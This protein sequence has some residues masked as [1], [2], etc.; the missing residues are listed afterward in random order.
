MLKLQFLGAAET[1]TG[2]KY[3]LSYKNTKLLIDCGL[4]QGTKN[5][6]Q[7]NWRALAVAETDID[8]VILTHAH[9]DHSGY[10][11]VLAKRGYR[12]PVYCSE[13]TLAL[14]R[15]LLPD[16]GHLQE[17]DARYANKYKVTRHH[18]AQAL[19]TE[20][21]ARRAL[22][23]FKPIALRQAVKLG[24]DITLELV[25]AG[26]IVGACSVRLRLGGRSVVFSGDVGRPGDALMCAPEPLQKTDYLI[27]ESTYG[28]RLHPQEDP[29]KSLRE[30]VNRTLKRGG[31]VLIPAFA[32][33]RA[34]VILHMLERL[35]SSA[36]IPTV[37]VYLNSPMALAA[38]E[39][40]NRFTHEHRL[41]RQDCLR[42]VSNTRFVASVEESKALNRQVFP[43]IIIS[44]SGMASGGR[45]IHHLKTLIGNHR[46]SV[47]FAGFQAP[48]TRGD[49][50]LKGVNAIKMHGSYYGVDAE[51]VSIEGLSA[52]ADYRELIDWLKPLQQAPKHTFITH[53]EKSAADSMRLHLQ[54]KLGW[55]ASVPEYLDIVELD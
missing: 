49:A 11:P 7:R 26:H 33:G 52:H 6:R 38:T 50:L 24:E 35:M 19:F 18:P 39:V 20:E 30:I 27:L 43:A 5:Y 22:Q 37:P 21:D 14:C 48:G 34:Q 44:A 3:L 42:I 16:A 1:V 23:L 15:I 36:Q 28:D 17:E 46:N 8:A 41:S 31:I 9:I 54:D 32:V 29:V 53:G 4:Y 47:V 51:V 40:F 25:P 2:S 45:V 13:G 10:L 55:P 12:G